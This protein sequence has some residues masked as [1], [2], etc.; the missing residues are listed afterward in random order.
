MIL[1]LV[2]SMLWYLGSAKFIAGKP[3]PAT[4]QNLLWGNLIMSVVRILL[5]VVTRS[6]EPCYTET[7]NTKL[8]FV[9]CFSF[10]IVSVFKL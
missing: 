7:S 5:S 10:N 1:W 2:F 6:D 9:L 4:S 3:T 8:G